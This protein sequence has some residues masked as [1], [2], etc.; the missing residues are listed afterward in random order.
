VN[1]RDFLRRGVPAVA[2][3]VASVQSGWGLDF[4][5]RLLAK[6]LR[7]CEATIS[8]TH[9]AT[10]VAEL[11]RMY[12][13]SSSHLYKAFQYRVEEFAWLSGAAPAGRQMTIPLA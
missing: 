2:V 12:K 7:R 9:I 6:V 4:F 3:T 13:R 8:H 5:R 10:T 11:S 1:R